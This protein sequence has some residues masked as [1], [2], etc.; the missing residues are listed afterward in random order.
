M[1][2]V[3][4]LPIDEEP[5]YLFA[6]ALIREAIVEAISG[7]AGSSKLC[8]ET[9]EAR[10]AL[11]RDWFFSVAFTEICHTFE[12]DPEVIRGVALEV[13]DR[14]RAHPRRQ[15]KWREGPRVR[16]P[17]NDWGICPECGGEYVSLRAH[18]KGYCDGGEW[19]FAGG[20]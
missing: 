2:G 16:R 20:R 4:A 18:R 10:S 19:E 5:E 9:R 14:N 7:K 11:S 8:P 13:I 17:K 1:G 6:G 15:V 12:A 3:A